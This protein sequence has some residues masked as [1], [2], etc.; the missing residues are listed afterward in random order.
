MK[1][2][3]SGEVMLVNLPGTGSLFSRS[4][5]LYKELA[6]KLI[7]LTAL[8]GIGAFLNVSIQDS[9]TALVRDSSAFAFA[10]GVVLNTAINIAISGFFFSFIF[11]AMIYLIHEKHRGRTL[12]LSECFEMARERYV[13]LFFVGLLLF[14]VMNGGL[15]VVVMPLFFSIWF[16]FAVFVVLLDTERGIG[17]LAKARYLVHGVFFRVV[18]RYAAITLLTF[19]AFSALW[20]LLLVPV[21]G[22]ALF[23]I[24]F[25]AL[26]LFAFPFFIAYEYFRYQDLVAVQRNIPFHPFSGERMGIAVWAILG[27]M[28]ALMAWSYDVLGTQGRARFSEVIIVRVADMVLPVLTEWSKNMEKSSGFLEQLRVITPSETE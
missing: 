23:G 15:L 27:V 3:S 9:I 8:F 11:A 14:F 13:A 24:A 20:L 6:Q 2:P 25:L 10:F 22:W 17:A 1:H 18:G 12:T 5:A 19:I 28:I 7:V 26:G 4:W 21:I 16:Y